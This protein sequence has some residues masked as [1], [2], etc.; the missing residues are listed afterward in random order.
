MLGTMIL[1]TTHMWT[2]SLLK[3]S[4]QTEK[5]EQ[6]PTVPNRVPL[7]LETPVGAPVNISD[8]P[9]G[10]GSYRSAA[11]RAEIQPL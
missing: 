4:L 10:Q 3:R 8:K 1:T 2:K 11:V 9:T 7:I 6:A 5:A